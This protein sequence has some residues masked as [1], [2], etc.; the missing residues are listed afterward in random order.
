MDRRSV[1]V[2]IVAALAA[3]AIVKAD[4]LMKIA[5]VRRIVE[6]PQL[7]VPVRSGFTEAELQAVAE[8]IWRHYADTHLVL[9]NRHFREVLVTGSAAASL[10][11]FALIQKRHYLVDHHPPGPT[12]GA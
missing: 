9:M 8:G 1:L 11:D 5:S 3:P 6:L 2:G 10:P 12:T 4:S 7:V